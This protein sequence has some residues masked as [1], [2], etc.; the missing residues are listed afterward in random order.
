MDWFSA[1]QADKETVDA[2]VIDFLSALDAEALESFPWKLEH[3]D[4]AM[5]ELLGE[6]GDALLEACGYEA[7][8]APWDADRMRGYFDMIWETVGRTE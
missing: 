8:C 7:V 2:A 1:E 5:E 4:A 6:N 3:V